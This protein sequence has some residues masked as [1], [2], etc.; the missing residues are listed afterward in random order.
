MKS[1]ALPYWEF[2]WNS[3]Y[4]IIKHQK[5]KTKAEIKGEKSEKVKKS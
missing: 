4:K 5:R 1:D 3:P 2:P